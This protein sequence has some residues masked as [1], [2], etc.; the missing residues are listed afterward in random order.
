MRGLIRAAVVHLERAVRLD[1]RSDLAHANLAR[2]VRI[3]RR[4]RRCGGAGAEIV[5]LATYHVAPVLV[6]G[7]VY[8]DLGRSDDAVEHVRRR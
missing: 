6:A 3:G 4:D 7:E 5:R 1:P 8:E 2:R